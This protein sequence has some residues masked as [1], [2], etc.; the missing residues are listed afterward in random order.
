LTKKVHKIVLIYL[1]QRRRFEMKTVKHVLLV[2]G[3][4]PLPEEVLKALRTHAPR[5]LLAFET[6]VSSGIDE[7]AHMGAVRERA[8]VAS[9][10]DGMF[11]TALRPLKDWGGAGT[12]MPQAVMNLLRAV[13]TSYGYCH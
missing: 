8:R 9:V 5:H 6:E 13:V 7:A 12:T 2:I 4:E 10:K 3:D 1:N 11:P